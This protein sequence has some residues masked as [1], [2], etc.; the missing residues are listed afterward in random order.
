MKTVHHVFANTARGLT[1]DDF[2]ISCI[3]LSSSFGILVVEVWNFGL[4]VF[5]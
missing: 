3:S 1:V 2:K 5:V 4:M